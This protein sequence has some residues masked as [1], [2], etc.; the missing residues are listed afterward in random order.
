M[1]DRKIKGYEYLAVRFA[2]GLGKKA[3]KEL[4]TRGL[5]ADYRD[6]SIDGLIRLKENSK[7]NGLS[8]DL[9]DQLSEALKNLTLIKRTSDMYLEEA[10]RKGMDIVCEDDQEYPYHWK[11]LAG[12][13]K[14]F[15]VK[16]KKEILTKC[17]SNG[18]ASIVGSR[19]PGRYALYACEDFTAKLADKD[20]VIVS[21]LA[22]GIDRQAHVSALDNKASTIAVTAGGLDTI[23]PY[24]NKD[25]FERIG[26]EGLLLS[27][28]PPGQKVL[29]QYFP[30]RNRLIA[31]LSDVCLIME[32]GEF[33]GTL[34]T[35]SFAASQGK[36]V[37]VL[38]NNIY[39][40]NARGGLYLIRDGAEVLIDPQTV[41][42]RIKAAI[43]N[44]YIT[45]GADLK[46]IEAE[47]MEML[48]RKKT[49]R[50]QDLN[51][52]E[53][54]LLIMDELSLGARDADELM[55]ILGLPY[56]AVCAFL[57][58]LEHDRKAVFEKGKYVLTFD[59]R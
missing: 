25:L 26:N 59:G 5:F 18:T 14:V 47:D 20:V 8:Q 13:P 16:G 32:A 44:R 46:E 12:M 34:H 42:D 17:F 19:E 56:Q 37:F 21:G 30:S 50:P 11:I 23:Y 49:L 24:Q 57:A 6:L 51:G 3:I 2:S 29:R 55:F 4:R 54:K 53:W 27:E 45:A 58:E 7:E 28:M 48:R 52:E 1:E 35:A 9:Q 31:G 38:P 39:Y 40:D 15:F 41:I 10:S 33:S 36:D 22:L 43:V